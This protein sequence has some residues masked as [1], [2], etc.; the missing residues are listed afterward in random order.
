MIAS[1][2]ATLEFFNLKN[3][4]TAWLCLP[5]KY[6]AAKMMIVR[7]LVGNLNLIYSKPTSLPIISKTNITFV[8]MV[9]NQVFQLLNNASGKKQLKQINTLLI[10][11]GGISAQLER[12]LSSIPSL[13]AWHTYGM[14]ETITHIALRELTPQLNNNFIP[15]PNISIKTN[16]SSQLIINA[17]S[18]GVNSLT[19]NDIAIINIDNSFKILGRTDN[20]IISGGIKINPETIEKAII[21]YISSSFFIGSIPDIKLGEKLLLFIE[22]EKLKSSQEILQNKIK[23]VLQKFEQPKGIIYLEKFTRTETGKIQRKL[24]ISNYLRTIL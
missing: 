10:G 1:A 7:S 5:Y 18:I 3:G 20:V 2:K 6:I 11:G 9:P 23:S 21:P 4:D 24:L 15:L 19:T 22:G 14:T 16:S 12:H 8:A 13:N 17:P